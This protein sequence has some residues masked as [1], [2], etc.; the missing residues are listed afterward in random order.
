MKRLSSLFPLIV[1]ALLAGAS[2]WLQY[3][4]QQSRPGGL[5]V[6]RH[7][8]DAYIEHFEIE[9]F[10]PDGRLQ[11]RL[12]APKAVHYPD[13]DIADMTTPRMELNGRE[14]VTTL[15]S[16]RAVASNT[17][18]K[19]IMTGNVRGLQPATADRPEQTLS[20]EELTVLTDDQI[21]ITDKPVVVTQGQSRLEG[22]GAEWNNITGVLN[23][24]QARATLPPKKGK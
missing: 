9:R 23:M 4:V 20:T 11:S 21:A 8:P 2:Y 5:G 14:R 17:E 7:D 3:I 6:N 12:S 16:D 15:S 1:V 18:Q 19:V 10:G 22:V 13:N 24:N